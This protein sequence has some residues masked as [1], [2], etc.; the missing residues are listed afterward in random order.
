MSIT[1]VLARIRMS[2]SPPR[3]S[4][5]CRCRSR[6]TT[7]SKRWPGGRTA[8]R[9]RIRGRCETTL[10]L[11]I[12]RAGNV[13][14]EP[15]IEEC[16]QRSGKFVQQLARFR[17]SDQSASHRHKVAVFF[18]QLDPVRAFIR[19]QRRQNQLS[20]AG[21]LHIEHIPRLGRRQH[22]A[23]LGIGRYCHKGKTPPPTPSG[24]PFLPLPTGQPI[25]QGSTPFK[26]L[27]RRS[28]IR[29]RTKFPNKWWFGLRA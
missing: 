9:I 19:Y 10:G 27:T 28:C 20:V 1:T 24:K 15:A 7:A 25:P 12:V 6:Q 14:R 4:P 26:A 8:A 5:P 22:N 21:I 16:E 29:V 2:S 23:L 17:L 11:Q 3:R 18:H 13:H